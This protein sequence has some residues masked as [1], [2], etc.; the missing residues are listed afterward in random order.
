MSEEQVNLSE[1]DFGALDSDTIAGANKPKQLNP[2]ACFYAA[3]TKVEPTFSKGGQAM[4]PVTL[5]PCK[6][7]GETDTA[8]TREGLRMWIM[9]PY[10]MKDDGTLSSESEA[11]LECSKW[12]DHQNTK[13]AEKDVPEPDDEGLVR[14]WDEAVERALSYWGGT[15]RP[16]R[17]LFGKDDILFD[18]RS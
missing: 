4:L 18:P 17:A 1:L 7:A 10:L 5:S 6:T 16:L 13:A 11:A 12:R 8:Q 3:V 2:E 15:V 9:L 14:L